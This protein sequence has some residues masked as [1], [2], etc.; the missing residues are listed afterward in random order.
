MNSHS[1]FT[2]LLG[3]T[4]VMA[5][6]LLGMGQRTD[7]S[8]RIKVHKT[9]EGH[10]LQVEED[11]PASDA[12]DLQ[13]LMNKYG[14]SDEL[15]E[16]KPGEEVEIVIRRKQSGDETSDVTIEMDRTPT[17]APTQPNPEPIPTP[18]PKPVERK[19]AF[20]GV[21]YEM[22]VGS[23]SGSH[24][25][26]VEPNTPASRAGL[27]EGDILTHADGVALDELEDLADI[28]GKK[29]AGDKVKV[30][31]IREGKP[32]TTWVV[33]AERDEAFFKNYSGPTY[34]EER[35]WED[36]PGSRIW[37]EDGSVKTNEADNGGPLLGVLMIQKEQRTTINGI[38]TVT[39]NEG[40]VV[41]EVIAGTA[42]S[43]IGMRKGDKITMLNGTHITK[44]DEVTN[45]ISKMKPGDKVTVEYLRGTTRM[46]GSG[47]LKD[48][49]GFDL[50]DVTAREEEYIRMR[51][52]DSDSMIDRMHQMMEEAKSRA[53][54]SPA[55]V[56]EFRM[57]I[58]MDEL[59]PVEAQSLS[60]RT[61]KSI[62]SESDLD[63]RGLSLSPN[64]STG[65]FNLNFDLPTRGTTSI[66]VMDMNGNYVYSEQLTGFSG[67]YTRDFDISHE[68]K[69]VYVLRIVQNGKAFT[70]K[71]VTQ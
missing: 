56:R 55:T 7:E 65:K 8:V 29:Y 47:I 20:L 48:R 54:G 68:A 30:A 2:K 34:R 53:S 71:I 11:V 6:P 69:G 27:K 45:L 22:E 38:E 17:P 70:R 12:Q 41:D 36:Q 18:T 44:A 58:K 59:T 1:M 19:P 49:N 57:V 67:H 51:G 5:L 9:Q 4:A 46:S 15:K 21:H 3:L 28:I 14:M 60:A 26:K 33:L 37:I 63:L 61:G 39:R 23:N 24:I 52:D 62:K 40:A 66:D 16:L 32:G 50:P 10:T 13:Q 35:Y 31:Y 42:A 25:T 64:P 43:E